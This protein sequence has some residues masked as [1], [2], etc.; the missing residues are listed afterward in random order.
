MA[1]A[2]T[3]KPYSE[4]HCGSIIVR[5]FSATVPVGDLIWHKDEHNRKV[6]IISGKG[7]QFQFDDQLPYDLY[8]GEIILI[9]KETYHRLL[10]GYTDLILEIT[11]NQ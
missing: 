9:P 2:V 3:G 8:E 6:K 5:Y 11:E 7:W 4:E 1:E 10:R